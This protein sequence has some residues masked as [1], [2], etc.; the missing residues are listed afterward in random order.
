MIGKLVLSNR[1]IY[2]LNV[3]GKQVSGRICNVLSDIHNDIIIKTNKEF[4]PKDEYIKF[5]PETNSII[6]GLGTVTNNNDDILIYHYLYTLGWISNSKYNKLWDN[7]NIGYDYCNSR[8]EY[9]SEVITIDPFGSIDLDD[10]FS[11]KS[12]NDYYW[13]DIHISDPSSL[14]DFS[15]PKCVEIL[16]ELTN[17]LQT[18]YIE[19]KS[20]DVIHLL[21]P[22]IVN[23]FSLLEINA[24]SDF[25]FRRA[26]SFCFKI[27]KLDFS[28][29]FDIKFTKL[30]TIKNYS[31]DAYDDYIN[32]NDN[33]E[34]KSELVTLT[35]KLI[36]IIGLNF[37]PINITMDISHKMI[38]I[39]MIAVN[40]YGGNYMVD[41]LK[42]N[43][44]ILRIQD[45]NILDSN[46]DIEKIPEYA[47]V[48]LSKAANYSFR[49]EFTNNHWTLGISNYA[50]LSSPMRRYIDLL[51]H[52]GLH[53][54]NLS[55][56][57]I[58]L[59]KIYD[60]EYAN[61]KIKNYKKIS[62]SYDLLKFIK[63]NNTEH[64]NKFKA[65]L[66]DWEK[67]QGKTKVLLV[68][69]QEEY[70]FVKLINVELPVIEQTYQLSKYMEFSV[71]LYYNSN[72]FKS[73]KFPFSIKIL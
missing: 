38:E 37:E 34:Y 39:F 22:K 2:K 10:G 66:F 65:C 51:N 71:E 64:S 33:C 53:Q 20:N 13:L 42:W 25:K 30:F 17:R 62:Y 21:P 73:T 18:C 8:I 6:E 24:D 11:F 1:N 59:K 26:I 57:D 54:N 58:N 5:D 31:Y 40:Y 15:N 72:N 4:S 32:K 43:K 47:R 60:L 44:T 46:F 49:D 45:E 36:E 3:G 41:N 70:K 23:I 14:F 56:Y 12:D 63:K 67:Y 55:Q 9:L 48:M 35:N 29:D 52:I 27:S 7:I 50:H 69:Y 61:K 19:S 16:Y 28:V 68:L